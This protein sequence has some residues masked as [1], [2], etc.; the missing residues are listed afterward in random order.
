LERADFR[1]YWNSSQTIGGIKYSH[2]DC[3]VEALKRD[4]EYAEAWCKLGLKITKM[5]NSENT[6]KTLAGMDLFKDEVT[7]TKNVNRLHIT[8]INAAAFCF[9]KATQIEPKYVDAWYQMG[10]WYNS[11]VGYGQEKLECFLEV[12]KLDPS[13]SKAW[14]GLA[15]AYAKK[16]DFGKAL[17][18]YDEA[19]TRKSDDKCVIAGAADLHNV[20]AGKADLL[21]ECVDRDERWYNEYDLSKKYRSGKDALMYYDKALE[22]NPEY[23]YASYKKGMLLKQLSRHEEALECFENVKYNAADWVI[24][25][26]NLESQALRDKLKPHEAGSKEAFETYCRVLG[27]F[28]EKHNGFETQ[29]EYARKKLNENILQH[30]HK[31]DDE[32][33]DEDW[34]EMGEWLQKTGREKEALELYNKT[35]EKSLEKPSDLET[36]VEANNQMA[37]YFKYDL[38]DVQKAFDCYERT[39][40]LC[41][42]S[43]GDLDGETAGWLGLAY[44]NNAIYFENTGKMDKAIE[45]IDH[46]IKLEREYYM[47]EYHNFW[48]TKCMLLPDEEAIKFIDEEIKAWQNSIDK[49]DDTKKEYIK[50][51]EYIKNKLLKK[52]AK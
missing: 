30:I 39:I 41:E 45:Y 29:V 35:V 32:V 33:T 11:W 52:L 3:C 40:Q 43:T 18:C 17:K 48:E 24:D 26:M 34:R 46:A 31:L 44:Q 7:I 25:S 49:D 6:D 13:I 16:R 22:S 14:H 47:D 38:S 12:T 19:I 10:S 28:L 51:M 8:Q 21:S 37:C 42:K 9:H 15:D 27:N 36:A 4:P 1:G 5:G 20:F 23:G 2:I 50:N